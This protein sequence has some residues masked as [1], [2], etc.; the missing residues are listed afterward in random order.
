MSRPQQL[1]EEAVKKVGFMCLRYARKMI[2][3]ELYPIADKYL[4]LST[5]FNDEIE[6]DTQYLEL[7]HCLDM[8]DPKEEVSK[9]EV[10]AVFERKVSYDPP[11]GSIR[12]QELE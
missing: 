6:S 2:L 12:I 5:I 1:Y 3:N 11:K 7:V 8:E 10:G 4:K 9:I